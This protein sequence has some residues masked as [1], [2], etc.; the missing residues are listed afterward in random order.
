M[1]CQFCQSRVN[2]CCNHER[3]LVFKCKS[4][5]CEFGLHHPFFNQKFLA[6]KCL[7]SRFCPA[8]DIVLDEHE[9][10]LKIHYLNYHDQY[11]CCW[12]GE[13]R[14]GQGHA[15][16]QDSIHQIVDFYATAD[17][18]WREAAAVDVKHSSNEQQEEPENLIKNEFP[19]WIL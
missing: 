19:V 16:C 1:V 2:K 3:F 5:C 15:H 7:P 9:P 6:Q 12:C 11:C 8:C 18:E 17:Q 13:P 14:E 10:D 4:L